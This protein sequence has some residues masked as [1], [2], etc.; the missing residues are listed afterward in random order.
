MRRIPS[1]AASS[2]IDAAR[3]V[4]VVRQQTGRQ[5]APSSHAPHRR[6]PRRPTRHPYNKTSGVLDTIVKKQERSRALATTKPTVTQPTNM[7][8]LQV[9]PSRLVPSPYFVLAGVTF[10]PQDRALSQE[11]KAHIRTWRGVAPLCCSRLARV[12][13]DPG[14]YR[15]AGGGSCRHLKACCHGDD[16]PTPCTPLRR[17][18]RSSHL[19]AEGDHLLKSLFRLGRHT[20]H[21]LCRAVNVTGSTAAVVAGG[22]FKVAGA[23]VLDAVGEHRP[24]L[25]VPSVLPVGVALTCSR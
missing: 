12:E 3:R 4:V 11:V 15:F 7:E 6:T 9:S 13:H 14:T 18:R 23:A 17:R 22:V 21:G 19:M 25:P 10:C 2:G 1:L 16:S 8:P 5:T 24:V 20:S